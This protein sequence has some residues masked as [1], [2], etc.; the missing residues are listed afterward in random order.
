[1]YAI[2][3]TG[4][5]QYKVAAGDVVRVEKLP[6]AEGAAV[7]FDKVL[8]VSDGKETLIGTPYLD[9]ATVDA[10]VTAVGKG[11]KVIVFKFKAKKG[12][13]RKQGH[14]QLFTE[15]EIESVSVGGKTVLKKEAPKKAEKP[16]PEKTEETAEAAVAEDEKAAKK[17][18]ADKA[19]KAVSG[20]EESEDDAAEE[21]PDA[22]IGDEE[23][24]DK[25]AK[26][27]PDD[28][29]SEDDAAEEAPDAEAEEETP[30]AADAPETADEESED[31]AAEEAPDADTGD[32]EPDE[33][34]ADTQK[35]TKTDI[36]AKLDELG[37]SYAKSAKKDEL[38][39]I[40]AEAMKK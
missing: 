38:L 40:L 23:S 17:A 7:K 15:I 29:E 32:G 36:I 5:K 4:G 13:R 9:A 1:M 39:A 26:E 14:R 2:F 10:T 8:A 3:E 33:A 18:G 24:E 6:D 31:D 30:A 25:V 11:E 34:P 19:D 35:M 22:E 28:E 37:A 27:A 20:D 12:Y 16:A 21:A